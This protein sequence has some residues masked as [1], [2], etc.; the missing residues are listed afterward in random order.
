MQC[1]SK[2]R[3]TPSSTRLG[4]SGEYLSPSYCQSLSSILRNFKYCGGGR[5]L[6]NLVE[7]TPRV[8]NYKLTLIISYSRNTE[9]VW[10]VIIKRIQCPITCNGRTFG[11]F[12]E[13][14]EYQMHNSQLCLLPLHLLSSI[15]LSCSLYCSCRGVYSICACLS[16]CLSDFWLMCMYGCVQSTRLCSIRNF[17]EFRFID[18]FWINCRPNG[19]FWTVIIAIIPHI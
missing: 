12:F 5:R 15:I 17:D 16:I 13:V 1:L 2:N 10:S 9:K 4:T 6:R 14:I 7:S 11:R 19:L 8:D 18:V 3:I